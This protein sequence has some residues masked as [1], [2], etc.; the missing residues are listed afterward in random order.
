[1]TQS[2]TDWLQRSRYTVV[3][4]DPGSGH[5]R[6]RGHEDA[7]RDLACGPETTVVIAE[8]GTAGLASLLPGDIVR[9]E[10]DGARGRRVVVVR[11]VWDELTSPE[12]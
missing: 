4:V 8:E 5:L 1:M 3:A 2:L 7:C 10:D 12:F 11:R 9:L 6:V